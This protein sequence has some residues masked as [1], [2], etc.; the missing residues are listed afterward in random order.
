MTET[1]G[2][3]NKWELQIVT[4]KAKSSCDLTYLLTAVR[5]ALMI[6]T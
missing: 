1:E 2:I 4:H 5:E 6:L 3:S